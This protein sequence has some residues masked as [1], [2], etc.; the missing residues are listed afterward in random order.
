VVRFEK[1]GEGDPAVV[2]N[3]WSRYV[4]LNTVRTRFLDG[5]K[6]YNLLVHRP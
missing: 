1:V 5:V 6:G 2:K 3:E 4:A